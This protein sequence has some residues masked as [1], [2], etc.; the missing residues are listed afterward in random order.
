MSND[1]IENVLVLHGE[2]SCC[3]RCR[4][5]NLHCLTKFLRATNLPLDHPDNLFLQSHDRTLSWDQ[6]SPGK[7][8]RGS[9]ANRRTYSVPEEFEHNCIFWCICILLVA[10]FSGSF[11]CVCLG[12][13]GGLISLHLDYS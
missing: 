12:S 11:H 7:I 8:L 3:G 13:I 5:V 6:R 1:K 4:I 9:H 2:G 10:N